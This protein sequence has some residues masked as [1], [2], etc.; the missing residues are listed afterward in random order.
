MNRIK[1]ARV[2][3]SLVVFLTTLLCLDSSKS[4]DTTVFLSTLSS[5]FLRFKDFVK[6]FMYSEK[7]FVLALFLFLYGSKVEFVDLSLDFVDFTE[8]F[9]WNPLISS[10]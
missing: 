7:Q 10:F 3:R 1:I 5:I 2:E 6:Q 8:R 4:Y 9:A